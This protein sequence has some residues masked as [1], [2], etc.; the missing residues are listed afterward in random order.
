MYDT[1]FTESQLTAEQSRWLG[2][3]DSLNILVGRLKQAAID[4]HMVEKGWRMPTSIVPA[5]DVPSDDD[6]QEGVF[7]KWYWMLNYGRGGGWAVVERP[8]EDGQGSDMGAFKGT[9]S[10]TGIGSMSYVSEF[11]RIRDAIDR[12]VKKFYNLPLPQSAATPAN[13]YRAISDQLDPDHGTMTSYIDAIR[14]DTAVLDGTA[15][16]TYKTSF[17]NCFGSVLDGYSGLA[18]L[19]AQYMG[20]Q[21]GVWAAARAD[22]VGTVISAT[23]AYD[24]R[25]RSVLPSDTAWGVM[26]RVARVALDVASIF[27]PAGGAANATKLG[28]VL[29]NNVTVGEEPTMDIGRSAADIYNNIYKAGL[30]AVNTQIED[31]EQRIYTGSGASMD[32]ISSAE[33]TVRQNWQLPIVVADLSDEPGIRWDRDNVSR[34]C[35]LH[36]PEIVNK[37]GQLVND[38]RSL[39]DDIVCSVL[40]ND[41]VGRGHYG[42]ALAVQEVNDMF[43]DLLFQFGQQVARGGENLWA[44]YEAGCSA[45]DAAVAALEA[46]TANLQ[47]LASP[48]GYQDPWRYDATPA[49]TPDDQQAYRDWRAG[50]PLEF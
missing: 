23:E 33:P 48:N 20:A 45:D 39:D 29:L 8:G 32:A 5:S 36:M 2:Q 18:A 42:P 13:L 4:A 37:V 27:I 34:I 50:K 25:A 16:T 6:A 14:T 31:V 41:A 3:Y 15:A 46:T 44:A 43:C 19:L 40:R 26:V 10:N 38:A 11:S 12:H 49:P 24:A 30:V 7:E 22:V 17:L 21:A 9:G 35:D 47:A 1:G 28:L